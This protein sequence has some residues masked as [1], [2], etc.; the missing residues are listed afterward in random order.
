VEVEEDAEEEAERR[1]NAK[2]TQL[3]KPEEGPKKN[4]R[5]D[6]ITNQLKGMSIKELQE[7]GDKYNEPIE[8]RDLENLFAIYKAKA[9]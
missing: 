1:K 3:Y 6:G 2:L 5:I 8:A 7:K 9:S 4:G